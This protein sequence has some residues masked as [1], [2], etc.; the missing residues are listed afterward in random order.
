[1]D[2]VLVVE[3]EARLRRIITLYLARRGYTVAEAESVVEADQALH[4]APEPFDV[5]LLDI[6]LPDGTG[7]DVLRHLAAEHRVPDDKGGRPPP[8]IVITAIRPSERR[9]AE[10][11]PAAVLVKPFP[12]EALPKLIERVLAHPPQA[13]DDKERD[14]P[15]R[16]RGGLPGIGPAYP[17]NTSRHFND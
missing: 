5:I 9:L 15:S 12:I 3:D 13:P 4:A 11:Q 1:M 8:S 10:F 6:N 17:T 16:G 2:R 14:P 7:W